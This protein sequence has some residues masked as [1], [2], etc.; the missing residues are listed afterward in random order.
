[1]KKSLKERMT[2]HPIMTILIMVILTIVVSG[3]LSLLGISS[4]YTKVNPGIFDSEPVTVS[5]TSLFSLSGLKYIFTS[6]VRNFV[7]FTPLSSLI[8]IVIGIG[9][10]E[11]SGFLKTAITLLTK[12]ARKNTVTFVIVL[13]SILASITGDLAYV[14]IMPISALIF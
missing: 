4:T 10:M 7:N 3:F 8:I 1:M 12:K 6:T 2:L 14:V 5:V 9:V 11:K 13:I